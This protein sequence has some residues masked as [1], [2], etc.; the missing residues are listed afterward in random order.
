MD[1]HRNGGNQK[2]ADRFL[3]V[4]LRRLQSFQSLLFKKTI[5][6]EYLI[7]FL[8]VSVISITILS[9]FTDMYVFLSIKQKYNCFQ[10]L[11]S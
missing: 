11:V 9:T 10:N 3:M 4:R 1:F 8:L 6:N 2:Q 7:A 5:K